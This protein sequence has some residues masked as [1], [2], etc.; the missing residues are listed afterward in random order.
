MKVPSLYTPVTLFPFKSIVPLFEPV[1]PC[2]AD[3][4]IVLSNP[5]P[6]IFALLPLFSILAPAP[7]ANKPVPYFVPLAKVICL[8]FVA[9][10]WLW[11]TIPIF[12]SFALVALPETFIVPLFI[13]SGVPEA[14]VG[15]APLSTLIPILAV[16][17][18]F[19]IPF[20]SFVISSSAST[21][22]IIPVFPLPPETFI[23]PLLTTIPL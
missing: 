6:I 16:P 23:V 12:P 17:L 22:R 11:A 15:T 9:L 7:F 5:E 2:K 1:V 13:A 20:V 10:A 18:T 21:L 19:I 8:L 14:P 3:I 4:P